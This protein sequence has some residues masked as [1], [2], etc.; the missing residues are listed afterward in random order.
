[1]NKSANPAN[2]QGEKL[3]IYVPFRGLSRQVDR[4]TCVHI[5]VPRCRFA[6]FADLL[7]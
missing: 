1:M 7:I 4:L 5:D 6:G 2:Q 3:A